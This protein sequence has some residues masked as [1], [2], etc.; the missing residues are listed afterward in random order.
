MQLNSTNSQQGA[1]NDIA[2]DNNES[3]PHI[4]TI[5]SDGSLRVWEAATLAG[6]GSAKVLYMQYL[7]FHQVN[8]LYTG[9]VFHF[10][11]GFFA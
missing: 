9:L 4:A 3:N 1:L 5:G 7:I 2:I 8:A 10:Q 11:A 6:V